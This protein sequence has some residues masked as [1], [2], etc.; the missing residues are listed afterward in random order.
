MVDKKDKEN[1]SNLENLKEKYN[2]HK[3]KYGLPDF[4]ALNELFD[5]EDVGSDTD[6]LLRKIR[7]AVAERISGYSRFVD[8]ILNPSNAPV[9]FFNLIK[10]LDLKDK[11]AI[12]NVYNILGNLELEMMGL[13]LEYNEKKEAEFLIKIVDVFD[14]KIRPVFLDVLKKLR[15]GDDKSDVKKETK[16]SY[17]G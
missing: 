12:T 14:K 6:Y 13:D 17:F 3:K 10:K 1:D 5:L 8:V 7:R 11:E 9:F 16:G 4:S 15:N 2:E